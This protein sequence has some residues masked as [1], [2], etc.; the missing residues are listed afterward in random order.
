L[1]SKNSVGKEN[2]MAGMAQREIIAPQRNFPGAADIVPSWK[3][4]NLL[5]QDSATN[6]S[7]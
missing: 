5:R 1:A 3:K 7:S 2:R 4:R 6:P